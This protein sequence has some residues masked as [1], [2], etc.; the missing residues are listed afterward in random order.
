MCLEEAAKVEYSTQKR[1]W[2]Q[3]NFLPS[4]PLIKLAIFL[5]KA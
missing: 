1:T 2:E 4:L 3:N 5:R